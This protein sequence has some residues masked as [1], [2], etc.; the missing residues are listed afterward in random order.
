[1]GIIGYENWMRICA[2][3]S[4]PLMSLLIALHVGTDVV[5]ISCG[6]TIHCSRACTE[7]A[8]DAS[9]A[10]SCTTERRWTPDVDD[11]C[12]SKQSLTCRATT[13]SYIGQINHAIAM[14]LPFPNPQD[15]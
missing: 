14:Q 11:E 8:V 12:S 3:V 10:T 13:A 5:D 4:Q 6:V 15:C 7:P 1:M 2:H 9:C